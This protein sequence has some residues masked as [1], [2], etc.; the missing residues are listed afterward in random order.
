MLAMT[1]SFA[2]LFSASLVTGAMFGVWLLFN[3]KG[4]DGPRYVVLHLQGMHTLNTAL[5]ALGAA[6][7]IL[8][9]AAAVMARGD[10]ERL[11]LLTGAVIAFLAAA[12]ITRLVNQ[13][14]NL[15]VKTWSTVAPPP[16]WTR[17]RDAWRLWHIVRLI[18]GLGGLSGVILAEL[19][20]SAAS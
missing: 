8:T 10:G 14:I 4:L 19:L 16:E 3:P 17:L 1:I 15:V 12:A 7:I 20:R 13:P 5:P 6:T 2:N 9:T 18:C 11:A